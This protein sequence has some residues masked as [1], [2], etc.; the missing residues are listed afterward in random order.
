MSESLCSNRT[1]LVCDTATI[2]ITV[3]DTAV[4]CDLPNIFTPNGDG[5]NDEFVIPCNEDNPKADLK[6]Y[7]RW[8]A[9]VWNSRGHYGNNWKGTNEQGTELPDG[10]YYFIY[11]YNDI[12]QENANRN[13]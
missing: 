3:I 5:V 13:S 2:C 4:H 12:A 1:I 10:T 7:D 6:I 8:G 11:S 9:E